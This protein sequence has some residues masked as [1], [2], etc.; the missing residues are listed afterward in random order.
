MG[1]PTTAEVSG[2]LEH[3]L[4]R[5]AQL[6]RESLSRVVEELPLRVRKPAEFQRVLKLDRSLASRVLR[7]IQLRDPLASLH[8][9]PGPHGIRLLL[10]AAAKGGASQGAIA[11]AEQALVELEHLVITE[12]G[13]WKELEAAL[14]GWLPDIREQFEIA[15]RQAAFKGMSNIRGITAETELSV[16][17]IHPGGAN[18]DWVDRAC[19]TG[20]CGMKRLRPGAPMGLLHGHSIAP[21]PGRQ[22]LSL[23]GQPIDHEHGPGLL[24]EFS[25]APTPRFD[26]VLEGDTVHYLLEGDGV[27]V[28][29]VVDLLFA[30]VTHGRYPAHAGVSLQPASPGA[31]IDVPVRTLIVD[32]LV[33]EDVWPGV[34]PELRTYDTAGRG[35]ANPTDAARRMDRRDVLESIQ[36]LGTKISRFRIKAVA[37]YPEMIRFVCDKLGWDSG[38]FRG[39]RC[40]VDFPVYGYQL[41]MI[42]QPPVLDTGD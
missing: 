23:D 24:R 36:D 22:R 16:T 15:N 17:L 19:I 3:R 1:G 41:A 42:F 33:H 8:R 9:L 38:R 2:P 32:V 29:S 6:V 21:P 26:V 37:R 27:G 10:K 25:T 13:D 14:C 31:V 5:A 4:S 28:D 18:A 35:L 30:D 20:L 34:E 11:R 40:H 12:I 39:F 7:A